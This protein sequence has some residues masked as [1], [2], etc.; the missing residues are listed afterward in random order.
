MIT[1]LKGQYLMTKDCYRSDAA[2]NIY[3]HREKDGSIHVT[4]ITGGPFDKAVDEQS[5]KFEA[6]TGRKVST[7]R[8]GTIV[9]EGTWSLAEYEN[10]LR[11]KTDF[12]DEQWAEMLTALA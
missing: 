6:E 4:H 2:P 7:I 11:R 3:I 12:T 8:G 5:N 9:S 10:L 1:N